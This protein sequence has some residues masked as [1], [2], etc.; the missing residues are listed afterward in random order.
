MISSISK[1]TLTFTSGRSRGVQ[2]VGSLHDTGLPA[3]ILDPPC[4][5]ADAEGARIRGENEYDT[6]G[7]THRTINHGV[8]SIE[9]RSGDSDDATATRKICSLSTGRRFI[10]GVVCVID[11][12][13]GPWSGGSI[14]AHRAY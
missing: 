9:F 6:A 7:L 10:G 1:R 12:A 13:L 11:R 14:P 3:S 5:A 2:A 8:T 4:P